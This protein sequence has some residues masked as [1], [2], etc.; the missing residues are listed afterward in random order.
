[1]T[2]RV[3][4]LFVHRLFQ[5]QLVDQ[6]LWKSAARVWPNHRVQI[7]LDFLLIEEELRIR[8]S[9]GFIVTGDGQPHRIENTDEL[10]AWV[11]GVATEIRRQPE[12]SRARSRRRKW[13]AGSIRRSNG[14]K[15]TCSERSRRISR[16]SGPGGV[17]IAARPRRSGSLSPI[18]RLSMGQYAIPGCGLPE[19]WMP[20]KSPSWVKM[21][22]ERGRA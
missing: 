13:L 10:R 18:L 22:R 2:S 21:T 12:G 8:P 19:P 9:H 7:G 5:P 1:M 16:K 4:T 3:Q 14:G 6:D 17:T 15:N 20:R 11:L